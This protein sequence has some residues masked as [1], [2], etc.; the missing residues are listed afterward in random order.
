M[1]K[2]PVQNGSKQCIVI[3]SGSGTVNLC[4][5]TLHSLWTCEDLR[6]FACFVSLIGKMLS[7]LIP[8]DGL[9][10]RFFYFGRL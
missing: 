6:S 8:Q 5:L 4:R 3:F 1:R 7:H 9:L 10:S 2:E